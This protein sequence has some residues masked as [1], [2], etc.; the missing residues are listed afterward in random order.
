M[1]R[2]LNADSTDFLGAT[3]TLLS[4]N[5][6]AYCENNPVVYSD[7][8]GLFIIKA[9]V[10]AAVLDSIF[11]LLNAAMMS[12]YIGYSATISMLSKSLITLKAAKVLFGTVVKVFIYGVYNTIMHVIRTA[13]YRIAGVIFNFVSA[14]VIDSALNY[15]TGN[16]SALISMILT[17]GG[18]IAGVLDWLTDKKLD[19][20]I[21]I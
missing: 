12:G 5:L 4:Y 11:L 14:K 8:L 1:G 15:F 9:W 7:M 18:L 20:N 2:F 13:L 6:F 21:V 16:L 19:G 10:V 3:G 17:W